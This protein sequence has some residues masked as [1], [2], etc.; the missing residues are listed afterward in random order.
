MFN[1]SVPAETRLVPFMV[2]AALNVKVPAPN[3]VNP[4]ALAVP[5]EMLPVISPA[6]LMSTINPPVAAMTP[7]LALAIDTPVP[8]ELPVMVVEPP[9]VMLEPLAK[10][11]VAPLVLVAPVREIFPVVD[12][13]APALLMPKLA[14][15]LPIIVRLS[16][17][18]I[19]PP[20]LLMPMPEPP[21]DVPV[22]EIVPVVLVIELE[23]PV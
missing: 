4:P 22:I 10:L 7:V 12:V 20:P 18:E 2:F 9:E 19:A 23:G 5:P 14:T 6:L 13:S 8:D 1:V 21:L 16:F 17:A 11:I 3:L 15:A